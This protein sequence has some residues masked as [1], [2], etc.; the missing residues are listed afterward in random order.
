MVFLWVGAVSYERGNPVLAPKF[1]VV[2]MEPADVA[3]VGGPL[4]YHCGRNNRSY[5]GGD[6]HS[7]QRYRDTSLTRELL[8]PG[9]YSRL[10]PRA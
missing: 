8:L 2:V 1:H 4:E 6:E 5:Y 9:P 7:W 10:M 3:R